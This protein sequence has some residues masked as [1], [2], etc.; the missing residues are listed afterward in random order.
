MQTLFCMG[1]HLGS[2]LKKKRR[3][4]KLGLRELARMCDTSAG[5]IC[6]IEKGNQIPSIKVLI[7]ICST[8][9]A[10]IRRALDELVRDIKA[11]L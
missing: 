5:F 8:L 10:S 4:Q 9:Q 6:D 11:E 7:K 3:T 2:Y 1:K